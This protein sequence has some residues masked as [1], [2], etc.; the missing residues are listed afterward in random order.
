MFRKPPRKVQRR[1]AAGVIP[2]QI[3]QFGL[4]RRIAARLQVRLLQF[5]ERRHQHFRHEQDAVAEVD[6]D[7]AHALD[8]RL[9][10]HVIGNPVALEQDV[11]ALFDL[12]LEAVVEI[13]VH[14]VDAKAE[15]AAADV[16]VAVVSSVRLT[17]AVRSGRHRPA[18]RRP[19]TN[20]AAPSR[21]G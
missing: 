20:W 15:L 6:P 16:P 17:V 2:Q 14:L 4:E 10:Q 12:F 13:V 9:G 19:R 21:S 7:D 11:D 18:E 8:Q 3:A 1:G 5:F